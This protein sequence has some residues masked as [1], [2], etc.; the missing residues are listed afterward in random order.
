MDGARDARARGR[1]L[2]RAGRGLR[3]RRGQVLRLVA[4][5]AAVGAR[6][7]TPTRRS[8]G[9]AR[10][11]AATSRARTSSR[12]AGPSRRPSSASAS[13]RTLYE[14]RSQRVWPGLDDKRLAA[15]NALAIHAFAEAGAV[16]E[17]D[18]L[19]DVARGAADFVLDVDARRRRPPAA[20]VQRRTREAQRLPRGPRV[21]ARG[22]ARAVRGDVRG[23]LVHRGAGAGRH[24]A[25]A[26]R[27]RASAAGSSRPPTTTSS[28]SRGAR[29]SRTRRS[30]PAGRARR[31]GCCASPRS[32]ASSATPT[33]PRATCCSSTSSRRA[34]PP[35]SASCSRRSS[36]T[37]SRCRRSRSSA[38]TCSELRRVVHAR[39]RPRLVL[40]GGPGEGPSEVPLL[41]GRSPIDDRATAYVCEAFACRRPV[42]EP[43]RA[44]AAARLS[45][46]ARTA[47]ASPVL[48][49]YAAAAHLSPPR[50]TASGSSSSPGSWR[51][52]A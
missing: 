39:P 21:P 34:T 11:R 36:S 51:S 10:R 43:G 17:R 32:P 7:A 24:A 3:G 52:S 42:T 40:A 23:A 45:E 6:R 31:S 29:T 19:L 5:G 15:W 50:A 28:S 16:L 44:R 48:S 35:P 26:V 18:D 37:C 2:Q 30:R 27:R 22:A 25:R 47:D 13:A 33:R 4:G 14:A 20:D 46:V 41:E 9:S 12:A 38:T 1:L 49:P 8:R